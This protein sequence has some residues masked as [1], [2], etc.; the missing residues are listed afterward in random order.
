MQ[1]L[2]YEKMGKN[3]IVQAKKNKVHAIVLSLIR[4]RKVSMP[5][6]YLTTYDFANTIQSD[7]ELARFFDEKLFDSAG[8]QEFK[9]AI[10]S[11]AVIL[12]SENLFQKGSVQYSK[13]APAMYSGN[14]ENDQRNFNDDDLREKMKEYGIR[15]SD[16]MVIPQSPVER[17]RNKASSNKK[18]RE[19]GDDSDDNSSK[20][21]AMSFDNGCPWQTPLDLLLEDM[22]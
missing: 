4:Q 9:K 18:N 6:V 2:A 11:I 12:A 10:Q 7:Q 16:P 22:Q 17:K 15:S 13:S 5:F 20:A 3:E 1:K 21:F 14:K 19:K 8:E